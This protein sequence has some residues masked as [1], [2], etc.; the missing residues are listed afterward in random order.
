MILAHHW[1]L[2]RFARRITTGSKGSCYLSWLSGSP[3][4]ARLCVLV[5]SILQHA[6]DL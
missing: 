1:S 4:G 6:R 3:G 5:V 2:W